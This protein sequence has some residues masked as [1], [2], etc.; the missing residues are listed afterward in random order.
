MKQVLVVALLLVSINAKASHMMGGEIIAAYNSTSGKTYV[1]LSLYRD[2]LGVQIG[3]DAYLAVFKYDT[4]I[5]KYIGFTYMLNYNSAL[6]ASLLSNF[7]YGIEVG[8]YTDS[9]S[10]A[11]GHYTFA[12]SN[13]CRNAAIINAANPS[14][15]S[16]VLVT[17]Y[18]IPAA[19]FNSTPGFL[20]IPVAYFPL[21]Q[22]ATYNPLPYD[23]DNDSVSWALKTPI[24][25]ISTGNL[26]KAS[27]SGHYPPLGDPGGPFTMN[28][29]TG[30]ITWTPNVI[31]NFIQAFEV[32]E[33]RNG[34]QIGSVI[35]DMQ[36][37]VIVDSNASA[38]N[39]TM[40]TP[41]SYNQSGKYNYTFYEPGQPLVFEIKGTN[42]NPNAVLTM[43]ADGALFMG[44]NPPTFTAVAN[45]NEVTGKFEWLPPANMDKDQI[46]AFR[47]SD[48]TF[49]KDATLVFRKNPG[50][51]KVTA[52]TSLV[53]AISVYPN[54]VANEINISF[55]VNKK[56]TNSEIVLYNTTGQR[57]AAVYSGPI[58]KGQFKFTEHINL[59]PGSYQLVIR[60]DETTIKTVPVIVK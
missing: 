1:Q 5:G 51:Q 21:G 23:A 6:S 24:Q 26:A 33:Y 9:L 50:P 44:A 53:D 17:D 14:G 40:I 15:E 10:L 49:I 12:F 45:G 32:G 18:D 42:T 54:P 35:R 25:H 20:S 2:V 11:P 43:T 38:N 60:S 8:V 46:V 58:P 7:P 56:I 4:Q 16:M 28:S 57:V 22:P 52:N 39:F 37:V 48:G 47:I 36:Y 19:G 3:P 59:P 55:T 31:G 27:V 34:V 41:Y 29:T 13:C 30:E